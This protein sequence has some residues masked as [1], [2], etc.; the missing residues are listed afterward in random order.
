MTCCQIFLCWAL[1]SIQMYI[2]LPLLCQGRFTFTTELPFFTREVHFSGIECKK[3]DSTEQHSISQG[4]PQKWCS[5]AF[6]LL[7]KPQFF[8]RTPFS[9]LWKP[10]NFFGKGERAETFILPPW[11]LLQLNRFEAF[12][13]WY[14]VESHNIFGRQKWKTEVWFKDWCEISNK[15][16]GVMS[17]GGRE[18]QTF[19]F[20]RGQ[21]RQTATNQWK[22]GKHKERGNKST[23]SLKVQVERVELPYCYFF[24]PWPTQKVKKLRF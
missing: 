22:V 16:F 8:V 1:V 19:R 12:G 2:K 14:R 7:S 3:F 21:S 9:L 11:W 23:L 6:S 5:P 17:R 20:M 18:S 15:A 13:K 10:H 4:L 24:S